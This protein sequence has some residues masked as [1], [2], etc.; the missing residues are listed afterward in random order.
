M[1][2]QIYFANLKKAITGTTVGAK[3]AMDVNV[4]QSVN[5]SGTNTNGSGTSSTVSTVKTETVPANAVG[6]VLMNLDTS[7]TNIRWRIGSAA[8]AAVGQQLQPGR[9]TAFIPCAANV[10]LCSESGTNNYDIQWVLSA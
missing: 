9:D 8:S 6:F 3:Q 10:S 5:S 1:R 7:S 4:I 2:A